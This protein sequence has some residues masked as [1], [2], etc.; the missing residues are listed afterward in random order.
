M[1]DGYGLAPPRGRRSF[2]VILA[3]EQAAQTE[4]QG[5]NS[6]GRE[7]R[8]EKRAAGCG[9]ENEAEVV[10]WMQSPRVMRMT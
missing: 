10:H 7:Q 5:G 8:Q 2:G 6:G 4:S 3:G 1:A 9:V